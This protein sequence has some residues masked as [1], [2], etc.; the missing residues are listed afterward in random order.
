MNW[1]G[2]K[3]GVAGPLGRGTGSLGEQ[4]MGHLGPAEARLKGGG[5]P[6]R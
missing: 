4:L 5:G 1:K 2:V 6:G 3:G